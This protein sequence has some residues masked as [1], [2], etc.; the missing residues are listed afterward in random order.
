MLGDHE[1][2]ARD[3]ET[4]PTAHYEKDRNANELRSLE[5]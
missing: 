1:I 3:P 5:P 2:K 4:V